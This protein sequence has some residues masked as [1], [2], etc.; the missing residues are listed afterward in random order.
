MNKKL[1]SYLLIALF[2]MGAPIWLGMDGY[3]DMIKDQTKT[4]DRVYLQDMARDRIRDRLCITDDA[5]IQA[6][7]RLQEQDRLRTQDQSHLCFPDMEGHW[8]M[9]QVRNAYCWRLVEGYPD[10]GFNPEGSASGPEAVIMMSRMMACTSGSA[11]GD[12]EESDIDW[13]KIPEWASESMHEEM[14]NRIANQTSFYGEEQ[15]NRLQFSLMIANCLG[16]EPEIIPEGMMIFEDQSEIPIRDIGYILALQNLG[17]IVGDN[18]SFYP[19]RSVTRAE[20][21]TMLMHVLSL[22]E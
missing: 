16:L 2:M 10:G 21:A 17:I 15:L 12:D 18:G 7:D 8:A 22:L 4:Q 13:G 20:A 6:R 9:E 5:K 11:F 19:Y 1:L 3:G 14:A